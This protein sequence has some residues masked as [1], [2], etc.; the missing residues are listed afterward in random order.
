MAQW[1]FEWRDGRSNWLFSFYLLIGV[2]IGR[3]GSRR[4][5]NREINEKRTAFILILFESCPFFAVEQG[6]AERESLTF[7]LS[8]V[9]CKNDIGISVLVVDMANMRVKDVPDV[10]G[11]MNWAFMSLPCL[12]VIGWHSHYWPIWA[13]LATSTVISSEGNLR[14]TIGS[15][16]D[17]Y[18]FLVPKWSSWSLFVKI[19]FFLLYM[20]FRREP[21]FS[22]FFSWKC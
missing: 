4:Q 5:K 11:R 13:T 19:Y 18:Q 8:H 15:I 3:H 2:N 6:L 10:A 16:V 20:H 21:L 14:D 1:N 17:F 7:P 12:V 22:F 9:P